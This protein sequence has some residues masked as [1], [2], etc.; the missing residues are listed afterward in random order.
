MI[1]IPLILNAILVVLLAILVA[2]QLTVNRP[3]HMKKNHRNFDG[4]HKSTY[5]PATRERQEKE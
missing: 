4:A 2:L 5:R 3:E 1:P